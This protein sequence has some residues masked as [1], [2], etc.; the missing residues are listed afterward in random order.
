MYAITAELGGESSSVWLGYDKNNQ[1]PVAIKARAK[2]LLSKETQLWDEIAL[3]RRINHP[4]VIRL[5]E[6][7]EDETDLFMVLELCKGG[8]LFDRLSGSGRCTEKQSAH[9]AKQL[10]SGVSHI[11]LHGI[12]HR[13]LQPLNIVL[14]DDK[15]LG[16]GTMKLTDFTF[17]KEFGP[18]FPPMRTKICTPYYVA[19]EILEEELVPYTEKVDVW[20]AGV[21]IFII[22]GGTPPFYGER[23]IDVLK[24]VRKGNLRFRPEPDWATVSSAAKDL[25]QR[26]INKHLSMRYSSLEALNHP[27]LA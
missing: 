26:M 9:V 16:E 3:L 10:I 13:D 6:T 14:T 5:I 24:K 12:S 4:Y 23:D 1:F 22:I 25:M 18:N 21:I 20:S 27:W 19:P 17:A 11:H 15:P 7:F 8:P 2:S